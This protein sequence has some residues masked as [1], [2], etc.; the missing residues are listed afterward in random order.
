MVISD[1]KQNCPRCGGSGWQPG[2]TA[3]GIAQINYDGRCPT[4][5]GRGFALTE[6]GQDLLNLLR[7]FIEELVQGDRAQSAPA[8]KPGAPEPEGAIPATGK[9][10]KEPQPGGARAG[11]REHSA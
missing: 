11:K 1:L 9:A 5:K 7:P 8:P 4:C 10:A 3:M 2:F 6:L